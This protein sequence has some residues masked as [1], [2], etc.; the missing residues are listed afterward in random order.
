MGYYIN[1]SAPGKNLPFVGKA[2]VLIKECKAVESYPVP[3]S[4]LPDDRAL[5]CVVLN[6]PFDAA[7]LIFDDREYQ[8]FSSSS[9]HRPK[10]WL[11]M[12][13]AKAYELAGYKP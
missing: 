12:D 7:A 3:P 10:T 8:D 13:R 5:V 2:P 11:T 9:D 1:E 4:Q 6:G